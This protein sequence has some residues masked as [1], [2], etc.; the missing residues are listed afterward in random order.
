MVYLIVY[1]ETGIPRKTNAKENWNF[2]DKSNNYELF[3]IGLFFGA[4][5]AFLDKGIKGRQRSVVKGV[6]KR[7]PER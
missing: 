3:K 4:E 2:S 5:F 7:S 1:E 6:L